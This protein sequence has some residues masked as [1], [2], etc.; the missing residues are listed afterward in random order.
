MQEDLAAIGNAAWLIQRAFRKRRG[1][2]MS[3]YCSQSGV[4]L[5]TKSRSEFGAMPGDLSKRKYVGTDIKP[6]RL[7]HETITPCETDKKTKTGNRERLLTADLGDF[8]GPLSQDDS[9]RIAIH[10]WVILFATMWHRGRQQ[11]TLR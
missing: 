7:N 9:K 5:R 4:T 1:I 11:V 3:Q 2:G 8:R 6:M 10:G